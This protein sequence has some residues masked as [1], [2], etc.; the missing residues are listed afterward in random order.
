MI[1]CVQTD[2]IGAITHSLKP[3]NTIAGLGHKRSGHIK[4]IYIHIYIGVNATVG[5]VLSNLYFKQS[6]EV[7]ITMTMITLKHHSLAVSI[8]FFILC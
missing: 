3:P 2:V 8:L 1:L 6:N 4:E 7:V 5:L